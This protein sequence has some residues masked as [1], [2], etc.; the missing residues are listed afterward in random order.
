MTMPCVAALLL[1]FG[2][3][4]PVTAAQTAMESAEAEVD[5]EL[6]VR[7]TR[8]YGM[9]R[10]AFEA[11]SQSAPSA[12]QRDAMLRQP[13]ELAPELRRELVRILD[14]NGVARE[15]WRMMF[16]R[17]QADEDLRRRVQSLSTPFEQPR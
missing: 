17:M 10:E 2:L 5:R 15:E 7:F 11:H 14:L 3:A 8:A 1:A 9:A 4:V 13:D 6:V 16:A 12:E